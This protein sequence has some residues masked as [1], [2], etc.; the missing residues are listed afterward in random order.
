MTKKQIRLNSI[1]TP[2]RLIRQPEVT[3]R[4]GYSKASIY[5]LM[6]V[7]KFPKARKAGPRAVGW[8]E[9]ELDEWI[10]NLEVA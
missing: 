5:R 3:H 2:D 1:H 7:G 8:L 6:I 4:T 9:S 10:A